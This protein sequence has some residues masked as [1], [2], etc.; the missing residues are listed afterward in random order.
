MPTH[1]EDVFAKGKRGKEKKSKKR[2][3][4]ERKK[5]KTEIGRRNVSLDKG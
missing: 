4:K 3:E 2:R 1:F 5:S